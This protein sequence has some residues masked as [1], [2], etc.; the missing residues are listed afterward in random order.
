MNPGAYIQFFVV[1]RQ[2]STVNRQPSTNNCYKK[3]KTLARVTVFPLP[4]PLVFKLLLTHKYK[5]TL[6]LETKVILS[7]TLASATFHFT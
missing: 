7:D 1:N 5:L 2:L 6:L 3:Q 4:V